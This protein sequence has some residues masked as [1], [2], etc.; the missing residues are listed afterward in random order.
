MSTKTTIKHETSEATGTGFHLYTD[1]LD[2]CVGA[3]V[4]H[5]R[6]DNMPVEVSAFAG[7]TSVTVT[8]PRDVAER[9]GLVQPIIRADDAGT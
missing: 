3:D 2:H 5:L 6:L 7:T 4:V 8:I 9:L 1:W